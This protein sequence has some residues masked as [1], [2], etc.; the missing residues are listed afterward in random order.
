MAQRALER[1]ADG[2]LS[3]LGSLRVNLTFGEVSAQ[4]VDRSEIFNSPVTMRV[5]RTSTVSTS[6]TNFCECCGT[7]RHQQKTFHKRTRDHSHSRAFHSSYAPAKRLGGLMS[8]A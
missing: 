6:S 8:S 3:E 5:W 4:C 2:G 1:A 7:P